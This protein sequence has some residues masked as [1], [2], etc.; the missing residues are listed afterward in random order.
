MVLTVSIK[1]SQ[2]KTTSDGCLNSLSAQPAAPSK[3]SYFTIIKEHLWSQRTNKSSATRKLFISWDCRATLGKCQKLFPVY[4]KHYVE[5]FD[6]SFSTLATRINCLKVFVYSIN[7]F[8]SLR[9]NLRV[10]L[11]LLPPVDSKL[12]TRITKNGTFLTRH[13]RSSKQSRRV[14]VIIQHIHYGAAIATT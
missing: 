5:F 8:L 14:R 13:R 11:T 9:K 4:T 6:I 2:I 10:R 3:T 1:T 7:S 12:H